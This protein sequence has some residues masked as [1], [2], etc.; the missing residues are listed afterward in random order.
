[1]RIALNATC[2]NDRSSGSKQRFIGL[3]RALAERMPTTQFVIFEPIDFS[4][5][6]CFDRLDNVQ[7]KTTNFSSLGRF[8]R[9]IKASLYWTEVFKNTHFDLFEAFHLPLPS[10]SRVRSVLTL[11]DIRRFQVSSN[12]LDRSLFHLALTRAISKVD[13]VVTVSHSMKVELLPYCGD[14]PIH[15][16]Y[17]G[18]DLSSMMA[19][20]SSIEFTTFLAKYNLEPGFL[21]SVGHLEARKNYPRLLTAIA[22]LRS[23]G[24]NYR[25][26][27][28]GNDSGERSYLE[29]RIA[30]LDLNGLVNI[31]C[32][33]SDSEVRTAYHLSQLFVFPSEYE[34]FG[35]PILE[36]MACGCPM[37]LSDI[38]VFREITQNRSA[39]FSSSDPTDIAN[40]IQRVVCSAPEQSRQCIYGFKRINE[41]SYSRIAESYSQLYSTL[42]T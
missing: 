3:Y 9:S 34:G 11:H 14:T 42:G 28:V 39:Y 20:P 18:V 33:L 26:L 4:I 5:R 27:I 23:W 16:V 35:I 17:N 32:G 37:A 10:L 21:L 38:P 41:F 40:V 2:F 1:M 36:A 25:L 13:A 8:R 22:L 15:V 12:I 19:P 7:I 24:A 31:V 6:S 30:A 29:S